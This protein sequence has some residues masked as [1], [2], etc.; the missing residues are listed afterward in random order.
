[1]KLSVADT[2][3]GIRPEIAKHVFEPF[4]TTKM[5]STG[6][7]LGLYVIKQLIMRMDG[8]IL[9][10]SK[11]GAGTTFRVRFNKAAGR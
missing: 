11:I 3:P 7:G 9:V 1:M 8:S 10:E 2:G 4:F 5:D 6:V